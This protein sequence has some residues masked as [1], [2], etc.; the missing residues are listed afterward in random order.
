MKFYQKISLFLLFIFLAVCAI[1][2]AEVKFTPGVDLRIRH[3]FWKNITDVENQSKDNRN[4]FR[5][6]YRFSGD[7]QFSDSVD[8][9]TRLTDE[10]KD[11]TYYP[12]SQKGLKFDIN[13]TVIDNLYLGV[14][15]F[16]GLP[17][18]MRFGRQDLL[19]QYTD[20]F[21]IADGTPLD[22][23]RTM[24]FNAAQLSFHPN[25]TNIVD[26]VYINDPKDDSFLPIINRMDGNQ[27]LNQTDEIGY[28]LDWKN[29]FWKNSSFETYYIYKTEDDDGGKLA[30]AQNSNIHTLG[31][32]NRYEFDKSLA[33]RTQFAYQTGS[34]GD[35]ERQ[36]WGGYVFADK[37]FDM[38]FSPKLCAGV[39]L[40]SGDDPNTN[41]NEGWDPLFSRYPW[42]SEL[43]NQSYNNETGTAYWTNLRMYRTQ[44]QLALTK[45]AKLT[46]MY[47]Y[48]QAMDNPPASATIAFGSG[49]NRGHLPGLRLDYAFNKNV[50]AYVMG[51]YLIPGN[52]YDKASDPSLFTRVELLFKF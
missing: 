10:F 14:K 25:E 17:V 24:Y 40:L 15:N 13:E 7:L 39:I 44:L 3:E 28:L 41:T 47:N 4:Y 37:T 29:S 52:Y 19:G 42:M 46:A 2:Q 45:K 50:S 31:V 36:G 38:Q 48:L 49:K 16:A 26:F 11:Y 33:L 43:Y 5:T 32:F 21:L 12:N 6:R 9:Y 23:S 1:A 18:N 34:Y 20:G 35:Y 30:Q 27:A 8:I 51:E 22:G